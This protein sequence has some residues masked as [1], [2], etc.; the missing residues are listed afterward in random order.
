[1]RYLDFA[2]LDLLNFLVTHV[3]QAQKINAHQFQQT[4]IFRIWGGMWNPRFY[5]AGK[6]G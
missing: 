1:M 4:T 6:F 2:E 5:W 3:H